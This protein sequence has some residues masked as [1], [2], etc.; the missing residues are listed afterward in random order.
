MD[1]NKTI[2]FTTE[3]D[4]KQFD[5]AIRKITANLKKIKDQYE[6]IDPRSLEINLFKH[7]RDTRAFY[8]DI[9]YGQDSTKYG[10]HL[11]NRRILREELEHRRQ[12]LSSIKEEMKDLETIRKKLLQLLELK[13]KL[14]ENSHEH[15]KILNRIK[16]V[17]AQLVAKEYEIIK[18]QRAAERPGYGKDATWGSLI[19]RGIES[20]QAAMANRPGIL[21]GF[22]GFFGGIGGG[23]W[24]MFRYNPIQFW[25][26]LATGS[27]TALMLTANIQRQISRW[28][29]REVEAIGAARTTEAAPYIQALS[30]NVFSEILNQ[31]RLAEASRLAAAEASIRPRTT[32]MEALG[33][34]L[35]AT[36]AGMLTGGMAGSFIPGL[37]NIVG[38]IGGGL[39]AGIGALMY[40]FEN[41][42]GPLGIG[43]AGKTFAAETR[44]MEMRRRQELYEALKAANPY[45]QFA[46]Q[47]YQQ[48]QLE[49]LPIQRQLGLT[50]AEINNLLRQ[51]NLQGFLDNQM[52]Q[53]MLNIAQ[54][55][56]STVAARQLALNANLLQ[57]NIGLLNAE[58]LYG[59][60]AFIAGGDASQA[61]QTMK[62]ILAS[63]FKMGLDKSEY[64]QEF[65]KYS[66]TLSQLLERLNVI[67][68]PEAVNVA[69]DF[70]RM[71]DVEGQISKYSIETAASTYMALQQYSTARGPSQVLRLSQYLADPELR[72][73]GFDALS[74]LDKFTLEELRS[75]KAD[76]Y[77]TDPQ[78][79]QRFIQAKIRSLMPFSTVDQDIEKLDLRVILGQRPE[80]MDD[81][82]YQMQQQ[83]LARIVNALWASGMIQSEADLKSPTAI[84]Q[85]VREL[86]RYYGLEVPAAEEADIDKMIA[87]KVD[88]AFKTDISQL[89]TGDQLLN[90][91]A[92]MAAELKDTFEKF[93]DKLK[94]STD[95]VDE[96]AKKIREAIIAIENLKPNAVNANTANIRI[97]TPINAAETQNVPVNTTPRIK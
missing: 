49:N 47:Q 64:R 28:P 13:K 31:N 92:R 42:L 29:G 19:F 81:R 23:L 22:G 11:T 89:P 35:A 18:L 83:R 40:N 48:Y 77:F 30:G 94:V 87:D 12:L 97:I 79:K 15:E 10:A 66:E 41:I 61:A 32:L 50:D 21:S 76:M 90:M 37:G 8:Q 80:N 93:S 3:I 54:A 33:K 1:N 24:D 5:E 71:I 56:G 91:Q 85:A 7:L 57:R 27:G 51:G 59:Q 20:A 60:L 43:Q 84:Y 36:G 53:A 55:G 25:G 58:R 72:K 46:I 17:Q 68:A 73:M 45:Y 62:E 16:E 69:R 38:G 95:A 82:E 2:R 75:G 96:F 63:A 70:A 4:T 44:A 39:I 74:V 14:N 65:N 52:R 78:Q 34:I 9:F 67:S 86:K 88:R 6:F 26:G